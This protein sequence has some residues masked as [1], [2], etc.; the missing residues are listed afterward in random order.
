[1]TATIEQPTI[2]NA[3]EIAT[4]AQVLLGT[5]KT[6]SVGTIPIAS[7]PAA[8]ITMPTKPLKIEDALVVE[9]AP[10]PTAPA[11]MSQPTI[12]VIQSDPNMNQT[13]SGDTWFNIQLPGSGSTPTNTNDNNGLTPDQKNQRAIIIASVVLVGVVM[14]V[15]LM[16]RKK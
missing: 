10:E 2:R 14:V 8:P 15:W 16:N 4:K 6:E 7:S 9:P 1:M 12:K 3:S 11:P 13:K 5:V